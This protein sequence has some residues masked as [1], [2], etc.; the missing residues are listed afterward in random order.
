MLAP[1]RVRPG[2]NGDP[3][4]LQPFADS[5][6]YAWVR[7]PGS[8]IWKDLTSYYEGAT[9]RLQGNPQP[10]VDNV[11]G[12]MGVH[13]FL[14]EAAKKVILKGY[15][16]NKP[17]VVENA[18]NEVFGTAAKPRVLDWNNRCDP[19]S[20][21]ILDEA[22]DVRATSGRIEQ[23]NIEILRL[24]YVN[25]DWG[26]NAAKSVID[27]WRKEHRIHVLDTHSILSELAI[28]SLGTEMGQNEPVR[29]YNHDLE[30]LA[31][32]AVIQNGDDLRLIH[33]DKIAA[34]TGYTAYFDNGLLTTNG[35]GGLFGADF[36][37]PT[38]TGHA[39]V[40]NAFLELLKSLA[41]EHEQYPLPVTPTTVTAAGAIALRE[42]A[43]NDP[44][45]PHAPN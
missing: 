30:Y 37:H 41:G 2:G 16:S 43:Q 31:G 14:Q 27:S 12:R 21:R 26:D 32:Q 18:L 40:A 10:D 36:I 23:M 6:F 34:D 28:K 24:L 11:Y 35:Q 38:W 3:V 5:K 42:E 22:E 17:D 13:A 29:Q 39:A 8:S 1:L 25:N 19:G 15:F 33:T 20:P 9:I 44:W 4:V 45:V 7:I